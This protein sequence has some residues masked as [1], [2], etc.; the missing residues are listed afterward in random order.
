MS[1][2]DPAAKRQLPLGSSEN[3]VVIVV[4]SPHQLPSL[5]VSLL[6]TAPSTTILLFVWSA[7][8]GSG[9]GGGCH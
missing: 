3:H 5:G 9:K 6:R 4:I 7:L 2:G 8:K 1:V